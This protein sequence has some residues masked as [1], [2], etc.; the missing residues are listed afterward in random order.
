MIEMEKTSSQKHSVPIK[1]K[2]KEKRAQGAG[3]SIPQSKFYEEL[4]STEV[5]QLHLE[6]DRLVEEIS[7]QGDLFARN[8]TQ[9]QLV[10]YK[11]MIKDFLK[12]VSEHMFQVE[13]YTGGKLK[14]KIYTVTTIIDE[15]LNDL[16]TQVMSQQA[17]NIQLLSTLDEIRGL[18]IDLVK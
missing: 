2:K 1:R 18:L 7:R 9:K 14:Q 11:S 3:G 5:Q 12:Y 17:N 8:P 13:H 10:L 6:F 4:A 16:T 15:K